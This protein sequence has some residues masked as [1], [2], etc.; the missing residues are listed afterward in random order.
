MNF[1]EEADFGKPGEIGF[2]PTPFIP[3]NFSLGGGLGKGRWIEIVGAEG[4]GKTTLTIQIASF[5]LHIIPNSYL[6]LLDAEHA[7]DLSSDRTLRLFY[8]DEVELYFADKKM[9]KNANGT[10]EMQDVKKGKNA[11]NEDGVIKFNGVERGLVRRP[12]TYQDIERF[13]KMFSNHCKTNGVYGI[14]VWDSLVSSTTEVMLS[15]G[16]ER[17]AYRATAIQGLIEKYNSTFLKIPIT[18]LV[19]NQLRANISTGGLFASKKGEG[20]MGRADYNVPGGM[21]HKFFSYQALEMSSKVSKWSYPTTNPIIEGK[22]TRIIPKKNKL[23]MPQR[24]VFM[25]LVYEMGYSTILSVLEAMKDAKV[26]EGKKV[27]LTN[28]KLPGEEKGYRFEALC[29]KLVSDASF[30]ERFTNFVYDFYMSQFNSFMYSRNLEKE[31]V[32]ESIILDAKRF[33]LFFPQKTNKMQNVN[34]IQS[35][36]PEDL[37]EFDV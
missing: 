21:A 33:S 15:E 32:K 37:D 13:F 8:Q 10:I 7:L 34:Q 12:E 27:G 6:L 36:E 18:Q 14:L 30:L 1:S 19:I 24:E 2:T 23:G 29:D 26:L 25:V 17:I 35:D 9:V 3:L 4:L 22:I 16:S 11:K 5:I 28:I 31:I 20:D